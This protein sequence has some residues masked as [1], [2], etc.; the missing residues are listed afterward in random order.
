MRHTFLRVHSPGHLVAGVSPAG[1]QAGDAFMIITMGGFVR[2]RWK[3]W[4]D[5]TV[6]A[7]WLIIRMMPAAGRW[8]LSLLTAVD[9]VAGLLPV[10][11][12]LFS[13][14]VIG[15]VP[16]AVEHGTTSAQWHSLINA[17]LLASGAFLVLQ[18]FLP[19]QTAL[20]DVMKYRVD[21]RFHRTLIDASLRSTGIGPLED[22]ATLDRL[23]EATEKLNHGWQTPGD[24]AAGM[25]RYL[26]RYGSL[27]GYTVL[28][29]AATSWWVAVLLF[30]STML[31]RYGHRASLRFWS[32]LWPVIGPHRRRRD[33]FR[34]L[35]LSAAAA[36]ELRVFGLT[37][38][39][40]DE[41]R[42]SALESLRPM[43]TARRRSNTYNFL[44]F[45]AFA[46]V[47]DSLCIAYIVH[48][49]T[50]GELTLT[51]L[52][53]G[54]QCAVA[55]IMLGTFFH[56][57]DFPTQF[58]MNAVAAA[59]QFAQKVAAAMDRDLA[60]GALSTAEGLPARALSF[61]D[62]SFCY[63][64][65]DR[66]VLDRLDLTLNAG[67]CTAIVGLNGAGKTTLV[68]LLARLYE[69]TAG[70]IRVD[71][72]DVRSYEVDAWR[73]QIGVIFQD[74]TRYQ[75]SV[76]DNIA[77]GAVQRPVDMAAVR[78]AADKVGMVEAI[79][80]LPRRFETLLSRQYE[81]GADLSGGQWQRIAIARALYSVDA[82]ARV[83]VLDEPTAALDVRA[84]T[85]FFDSFVELTRGLTTLLISHRFSSVR[86]ADR[87]VVLEHGRVI[88]DG[89]HEALLA[90]NGRY[91]ELFRLQAKRFAAGLDADGNEQDEHEKQAV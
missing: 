20:G 14:V 85:E 6:R 88:E 80:A 38:W 83:L 53:L 71:G 17:F 25:L 19:L 8:L 64:G 30:A 33:Y 28:V 41:F 67:E 89:T 61:D 5:D 82:G 78:A 35:G 68:K 55:A 11:F 51:R 46:L 45:T 50:Q 42:A 23:D 27:V 91:A 29:G 90:E 32:G 13:S 75:L 7:R 10:A 16:G 4:Y 12:V 36:K 66:R 49:A 26:T 65:S 54:L 56:E 31:F 40:T 77:V 76:I 22:Q 57:A 86:R 39:V 79:E 58:G 24:A 18:V 72:N 62:V 44:V 84:E 43:W 74:F 63:P 59:E 34:E 21:G 1:R 3:T 2:Q 9:L 70:A 52:A 73:Q 81:D 69:P 37:G 48:S 87:I 47:V 15:K 60:D